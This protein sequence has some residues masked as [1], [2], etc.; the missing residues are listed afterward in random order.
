MQKPEQHS[1]PNHTADNMLGI[2]KRIGEFE[3]ATKYKFIHVC[4]GKI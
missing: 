1:N 3:V 4:P 2:S